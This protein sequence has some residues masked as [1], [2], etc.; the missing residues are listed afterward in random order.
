MEVP[1]AKTYLDRYRGQ[2]NP[3]GGQCH[4]AHYFPP[5]RG[6]VWTSSKAPRH[7]RVRTCSITGRENSAI[8]YCPPSPPSSILAF[9]D[10]ATGILSARKS[11]PPSPRAGISLS[12]EGLL[13]LTLPIGYNPDLDQLDRHRRAEGVAPRDLYSQRPEAPALGTRGQG[14]RPAPAGSRRAVSTSRQCGADRRV[15]RS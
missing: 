8:Q 12:P 10:E 5:S 11:W 9:D 7:H 2:T 13:M 6:I 3:G 4:V 15:W 1:I 14:R